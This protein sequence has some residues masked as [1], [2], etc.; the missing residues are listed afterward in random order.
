MISLFF[1]LAS[2]AGGGQ[3]RARRARRFATRCLPLFAAPAVLA[4][5]EEGLALPASV[6]RS[7]VRTL[8]ASWSRPTWS[9]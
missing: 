1:G 4:W 9:V 7:P 2:V 6:Y 5:A 3:P 8:A